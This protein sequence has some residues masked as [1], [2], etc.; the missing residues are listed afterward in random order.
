MSKAQRVYETGYESGKIDLSNYKEVAKK[1]VETYFAKNMIVDGIFW[2]TIIDLYEKE[3]N[4][5]NEQLA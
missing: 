2:R 3:F 4:D 5:L 1:A